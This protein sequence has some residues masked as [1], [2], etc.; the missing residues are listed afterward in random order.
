ME[1]R[2]CK[3]PGV[4]LHKPGHMSLQLLDKII[5]CV[6]T[7][8]L[9]SLLYAR[10]K[11]RPIDI[12]IIIIITNIIHFFFLI[13]SVLQP[14]SHLLHLMNTIFL[15]LSLSPR[16]LVLIT[17]RYCNVQYFQEPTLFDMSIAENIQF[18]DNSRTVTMEEVISAA[19]RANV[20]N[21]VTGLPNGY[22][23]R[24]LFKLKM[25][26]KQSA[27]LLYAIEKSYCY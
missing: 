25:Y 2:V 27:Q 10:A 22:D 1:L 26:R 9:Y 19:R 12:E 4:F 16:E 23:T 7:V 15:S 14:V 3:V 17:L 21:F 8:I 5:T 24:Y 13:C 11:E 6:Y 20:H 18:G